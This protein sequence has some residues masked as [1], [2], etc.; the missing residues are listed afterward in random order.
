[1]MS[2]E[3]LSK[4]LN[5]ICLLEFLENY[6]KSETE[7]IFQEEVKS[8]LE[9]LRK[10]RE[11]QEEL[12]KEMKDGYMVEVSGLGILSFYKK[13]SENEK[14]LLHTIFAPITKNIP[15]GYVMGRKVSKETRNN[16][17]NLNKKYTT[18]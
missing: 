15:Y 5:T 1:M 18:L 3:R 11:L 14:K 4:E 9:H 10:A 16:V 17:L 6:N 7:R 12:Q 8:D 2:T 13:V